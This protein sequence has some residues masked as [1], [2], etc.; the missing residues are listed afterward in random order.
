MGTRDKQ[1]MKKHP[2]NNLMLSE[3]EKNQINQLKSSFKNRLSFNH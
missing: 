1:R 3:K 2:S